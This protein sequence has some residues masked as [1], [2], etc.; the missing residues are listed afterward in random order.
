VEPEKTHRE[1]AENL[2]S[3]LVADWRPTPRQVLWIVRIGIVLGLLVAL[4]YAYGITL[5]DWAKLLIVPAVIAGGGLWFNTQQRVREQQIANEHA[6]DETLQSYLE[7]MSQLLTDKAQLGDDLSTVAQARTMAVLSR[8]DGVRKRSVLEFLYAS[9]LIE[10]QERILLDESGLIR[11]KPIVRL[12][13]ADLRGLDL[14]R[15]VLAGVDLRGTDLRGTNLSWSDLT[16]ADLRNAKLSNADLSWSELSNADL[17]DAD[18][19]WSDLR[20]SDLTGADLGWSDLRGVTLG[21]S[22]LEGINLTGANVSEIKELDA[23]MAWL[24]A[25]DR[26]KE[27]GENE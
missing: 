24:N 5:W 4:G 12:F 11:R 23:L 2:I 16:G 6:Q 22:Q 3:L 18:L 1:R 25:T 14:S 17:S 15:T 13:R 20:G 26:R 8:L 27:T 7:G 21:G 19:S 10:R 9:R